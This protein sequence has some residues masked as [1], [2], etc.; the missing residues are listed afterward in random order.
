MDSVREEQLLSLMPLIRGM[1]RNYS[2]RSGLP[3]DDLVQEAVFAVWR[4]LPGFDPESGALEQFCRQRIQGAFLD[5]HRAKSHPL[6]WQHLRGRGERLPTQSLGDLDIGSYDQ[7]LPC[8]FEELIWFLDSREKAVLRMV[9]CQQMTIDK[10][11][12]ELHC[13]P[14]WVN[15]I[16]RG[17]L[18]KLKERW[19]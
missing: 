12:A 14:S 17:A 2:V 13:S 19:K 1:A 18:T 16:K 11:A 9:F 15:L 10:I 4:K 6:G 7:P 8:E 3:Y 5:Y